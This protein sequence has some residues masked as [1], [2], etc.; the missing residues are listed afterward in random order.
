MASMRIAVVM[1]QPKT[2]SSAWTSHSWNGF[3]PR[4]RTM[5][6]PIPGRL[7]RHIE[8]NRSISESEKHIRWKGLTLGFHGAPFNQ[9]SSM[10][11][12]ILPRSPAYQV[13]V[14]SITRVSGCVTRNVCA[15]SLLRTAVGASLS[16]ADMQ[17]YV[18]EM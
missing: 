15:A 2:F 1:F 3:E 5:A 16:S 10:N 8:A 13:Q 12:K 9:V 11:R 4:K 17:R 18:H 6:A 7:A 14:M